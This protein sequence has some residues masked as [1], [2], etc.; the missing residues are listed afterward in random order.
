MKTNASRS[1]VPWGKAVKRGM[2]LLLALSLLLPLLPAST[3]E[4]GSSSERIDPHL[5]RI[6]DANPGG[7][8]RVIV[9]GYNPGGEVAAELDR[10]GGKSK[11]AL[12]LINAFTV[13]IPA[14]Q[15]R[16]LAKYPKVKWV[17][18]DAPMS[19]TASADNLATVYPLS[20]EADRVW[21]GSTPFTG[22]GVGVAVI[23]SGIA[24][25][26]DFSGARGKNR[27]LAEVAVRDGGNSTADGYGHGTH[28]AGIIGS[29]GTGSKGK[30]VG[31]APDANLVN[32]KVSDDRGTVY[33][34][35]VIEG[36]GWV[37]QNRAKYKIRVLNLSL[38]SSFPESYL[39]SPLDAAVEMAWLS[40]IAVVV[41]AGNSGASDMLY[42]PANDPF[43]ITVGAVD[44]NGTAGIADDSVT[45]W[46]S[47]GTTQ[48][49]FSKPEVVAPGRKIVSDLAS[50]GAV[51][52]KELPDR[53]VDHNYLRLSGTSMAAPVVS[54]IAALAFQAHPAWTP[55]QMKS[56]LMGTARPLNSAASGKGEVDALAVVR[57]ANPGYANNGLTPNRDVAGV[58][59]GLGFNSATWNSATWNSATW[60]SATW[61]SA[62]W[63]SAT[64][65]S[66]TWNSATWNSAT[67]NSATWNSDVALNSTFPD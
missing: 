26:S 5:A 34:S 33:A 48:D 30:Y 50:R 8:V 9:Q 16:A 54:G 25:S 43:V 41:S 23:D 67:W 57:M 52:A 55:D 36:I 51:L 40:G 22:S 42:P 6:A 21:T 38:V 58:L 37:L 13:D 44:T 49:G 3:A 27:I 64:W 17:T 28:V 10:R 19:A 45:P 20:V 12:P 1:L 60:N 66:A 2:R 56:A 18:V 47:H 39:T 63:N 35:D 53:I 11:K 61:N 7:T 46:S 4:A 65:N 29:N 15:V 59:A 14:G 62:T 24:R 31:I 32:V